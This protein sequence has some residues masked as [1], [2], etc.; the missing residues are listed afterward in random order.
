MGMRNKTY[1][2]WVV[3]EVDS[4][5]DRLDSNAFD[6]Y[7]EAI[8]YLTG[9]EGTFEI[10]LVRN[11]G[12][13]NQGVVDREWAYIVNGVLPSEFDG[14]SKVPQKYFKECKNSP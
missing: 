10:C 6:T 5:G 2:E 4:Y 11:F 12:N 9:M 3:E 13:D 8:R 1:Y 7:K 14:G